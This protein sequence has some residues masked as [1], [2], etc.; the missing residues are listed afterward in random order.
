MEEKRLYLRLGDRVYSDS[1]EEWGTGAVVE[2]M[3]STIVGGTCLV[4]V[5]F[6]DGH[7]RTFHNDLDHDMCCYFLGVRRE[8]TFDW[9]RMQRVKSG[10]G[11]RRRVSRESLAGARCCD[12]RSLSIVARQRLSGSWLPG[13]STFPFASVRGMRRRPRVSSVSG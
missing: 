2:E 4:R 11:S 8:M 13:G 12:R 9:D 6:E 10:P 7:Q 1:H 3:T 5:L